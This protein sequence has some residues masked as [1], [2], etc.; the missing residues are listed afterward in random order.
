M[1]EAAVENH[2]QKGEKPRIRRDTKLGTILATLAAGWSLNRFEAEKIGDHALHSTVSEIEHR[3]RIPVSRKT[4][5]AKS[6]WG[7]P[8]TVSRYWLSDEARERA[9]ELLGEGGD[10]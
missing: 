5:Q 2:R 4:E 1:S 7:H 6:R 3:H 8:V 10:D 9:R